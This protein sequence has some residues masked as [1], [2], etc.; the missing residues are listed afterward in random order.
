LATTS[1][2]AFDGSRR[3]FVLGGGLGAGGTFFRQEI[4]TPYESIESDTEAHGSLVTDFLIG[5]GA[6]EQLVITYQSHVTWFSMTNALSETVTITNGVGGIS[7]SY[8]FEPEAPSPVLIGGM[9][10]STWDTPFEDS[11]DT[12]IGFGMWGGFGYEFSP[13]WMVVVS[14]GLGNPN[15]TESGVTA[16]TRSLTVGLSVVALAY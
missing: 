12:W 3:G 2:H 13:H 1:A 11:G 16:T 4:S 15:T 10:F 5:L 7:L 6:T 8:Y 14:M 9:G